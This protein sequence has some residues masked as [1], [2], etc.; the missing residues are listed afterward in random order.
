LYFTGSSNDVSSKNIVPKFTCSQ[1]GVPEKNVTLMYGMENPNVKRSLIGHVKTLK[2]CVEIACRIENSSLA[3]TS[4]FDC[5]AVTCNG[6]EE[7]CW[8]LPSFNNPSLV[9]VRLK[10]E[11]LEKSDD[12][13]KI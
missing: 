11:K 10:R 8:L 13:P 5:Y 4:R 7:L 9:F 1:I 2:E 12:K 6:E 3:Y